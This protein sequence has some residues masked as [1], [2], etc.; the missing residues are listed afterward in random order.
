MHRA[1]LTRSAARRRR[2]TRHDSEGAAS[3]GPF[4]RSAQ[5]LQLAR[6]VEN[7][8]ERA[9]AV[10]HLHHARLALGSQEDWVWSVL[11]FNRQETS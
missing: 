8:E 7:V 4:Q 9:E 2:E 1:A 3:C 10:A 6:I 11:N 5:C